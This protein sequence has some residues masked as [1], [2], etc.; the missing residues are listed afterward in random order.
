MKSDSEILDM[1]STVDRLAVD[2]ETTGLDWKKDVIVGYVFTFSPDP[3]DSHYVP[4]RH[5]AGGNIPAPEAFE[6]QLSTV[7]SGHNIH[8][9]GHNIHLIGHNIAFDLKFMEKHGIN[10]SACTFEDT[11]VNAALINEYRS[12]YSLAA[13]CLDAKVQ[14]KKGGE[15]Y[16]YLAEKFGGQPSSSQMGSYWKLAGDDPMAVEYAVGDGTSTWQLWERQQIDLDSQDL[17]TVWRVEC[18]VIRVLHRMMMRGVK[19]DEERLDQIRAE[20]TRRLN[21]SM[22][23]L[24]EG[25]N[26]RS[27]SDMKKLFNDAGLTDY[28]QTEKGNPSFAEAWLLTNDLGRKVVAARKYGNLINSFINPMYD[29]LHNGRVHTNFNQSRSDEF[30]TVTGRLSS[31]QPNMQ[32]VPKRNV[33]LGRLF[34]SI[35]VPDEG[36]IWGS[37]DYSQCEPRL[38]A[39]YSGCKVL[40]DGYMANPPLDS[41]TAV[42]LAA[43][44]DRTAGKRLNQGLI[45]G[46]GKAKLIADLGVSQEEGERMYD[47]YFRAMPEI[48]SLQHKASRVMEARGYVRSILGRRARLQRRNLSYKAVNRILQCGNADVIKKAMADVDDYLEA[49][50]DRA[51][52]LLS[53]HDSVDFQFYPDDRHLYDRAVEIMEDFGPGR[54]VELKVPLVVDRGEGSNWAIASYGEEE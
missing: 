54:S 43:G 14:A 25:I 10:L 42:A 13:C 35:F 19:V 31:S 26:L 46:M 34:R 24:P 12:S 39:H 49:N 17:R 50:G 2:V 22:N 37:V 6:R 8:L 38:L 18:R 16:A 27:S 7:L 11:M 5:G 9:I 23:S 4:V 21:E 28:P 20:V 3:R 30:G 53:I 40:V 1:I 32:Q 15:L 45:T 52:M 48:K 29:H 36:M 51:Q 41:H 44:I 47:D 33:E